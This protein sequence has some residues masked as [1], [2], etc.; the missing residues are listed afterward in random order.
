MRATVVVP[1]YNEA[2]VL[3]SILT[4]VK[5]IKGGYSVVVVDDGSTDGSGDIAR[6]AGAT[7]VR[8]RY[9]LGLGAALATGLA[10]AK[11]LGTH[12]AVTFDADGQHKV[13]DL[14][15]VL[16]PVLD[17]KADVVIGT[18][19]RNPKG[20]PITRQLLNRLA[21]YFTWFLFGVWTT[22]SQSGLRAFS[23]HALSAVDLRTHR[24]EASTELFGEIRKH[25]L[26]FAEVPITP[27]Y[28]EYSKAKGQRAGNSAS[29]VWK[30]LLRKLRG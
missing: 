14:M 7:V 28:T 2:P 30:L 17:G 20:M 19:L 15:A 9:N 1:V 13:S 4:E 11:R 25:G 16:A 23:R 6:K 8:H 29:I 27:I 3:G 18:R 26:R 24:M 5:E 12:A 22:D 21:N 10:A